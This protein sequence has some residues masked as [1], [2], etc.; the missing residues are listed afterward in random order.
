M[1][2]LGPAQGSGDRPK[3]S[4][5]RPVLIAAFCASLSLIPQCGRAGYGLP[6]AGDGETTRLG[7][8]SGL[9][10]RDSGPQS[11]GPDT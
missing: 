1:N 10:A 5:L 9:S 4:S 6:R 3:A 11:R 8:G 2:G 7:S